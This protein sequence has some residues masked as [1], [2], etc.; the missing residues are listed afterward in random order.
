MPRCP[1]TLPPPHS[2]PNGSAAAASHRGAPLSLLQPPHLL[3]LST[4]SPLRSVPKMWSIQTRLPGPWRELVFS[5]T[6]GRWG[7]RSHPLSP[8]WPIRLTATA[9]HRLAFLP[10]AQPDTTVASRRC[11]ASS[12][13]CVS[14]AG[15]HH[16]QLRACHPRPAFM[17]SPAYNRAPLP[18]VWSL[19]RERLHQDHA[20]RG[21]A[22]SIV[23]ALRCEPLLPPAHVASVIPP[24]CWPHCHMRLLPSAGGVRCRTKVEEP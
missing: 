6:P 11:H 14:C 16:P 17:T 19:G 5:R 10:H 22:L 4:E 15:T 20:G 13:L 21:P 24:V 12:N 2:G 23:E 8:A 7:I 18:R 3:H 9:T 1:A